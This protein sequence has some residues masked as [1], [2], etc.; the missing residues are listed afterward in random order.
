MGTRA[1]SHDSIF[2]PDGG[3]ES[4]QTVQAMSQDNILGKVKTLQSTKQYVP[5]TVGQEHQVWAATTQRHSHE[6]GRQWRGSLR[7]GP[8][9]HQSCGSC[10]SARPHPLRHREQSKAPPGMT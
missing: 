1:F 3:A 6:E 10:D 9:P 2:I 5:A 7:R 8:I 4:E